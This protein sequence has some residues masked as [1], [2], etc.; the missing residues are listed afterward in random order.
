MDVSDS[1]TSAAHDQARRRASY[2]LDHQ[3]VITGK[4]QSQSE[5][6]ACMTLRILPVVWG[7]ETQYYFAHEG[8]VGSERANGKY[9]RLIRMIR[10]SVHKAVRSE[11]TSSQAA[12]A[13]Q[14][15]RTAE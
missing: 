1:H 9:Q 2:A 13:Q 12:S 6:S 10:R 5:S 7:L 3:R 15:R 14:F 8:K 11:E 4:T